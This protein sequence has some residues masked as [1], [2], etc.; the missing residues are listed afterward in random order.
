MK[1]E[2]TQSECVRLAEEHLR[3]LHGNDVEITVSDRPM[4]ECPVKPSSKRIDEDERTR[5]I[6]DDI[7]RAFN[8]NCQVTF[9]TKGFTTLKMLGSDCLETLKAALLHIQYS[10]LLANLV[11]KEGGTSNIPELEVKKYCIVTIINR[12]RFGMSSIGGRRKF[13]TA[14]ALH[15]FAFWY[16][17][18]LQRF[19]REFVEKVHDAFRAEM[20]EL[21]PHLAER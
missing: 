8:V 1:I 2:L 4:A 12:L 11:T 3:E 18:T 5:W 21:Y 6:F 19:D 14:E 16:R 7:H 9:G 10:I 13:K 15:D 20:A 17:P